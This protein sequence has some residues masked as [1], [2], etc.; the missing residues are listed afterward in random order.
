M[1]QEKIPEPQERICFDCSSTD[2][3][4]HTLQ[5]PVAVKFFTGGRGCFSPRTK[6]DWVW[7]CVE[8]GEEQT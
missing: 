4:I 8:C 5:E 3:I 2:D 7:K 6:I 1:K